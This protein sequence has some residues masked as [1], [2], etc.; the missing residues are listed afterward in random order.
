MITKIGVAVIAA[1][2]ASPALA[3][4]ECKL[5]TVKGDR[6]SYAFEGIGGDYVEVSYP[7][8]RPKWQRISKD[9]LVPSEMPD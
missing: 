3:S 7:D 1:L 2:I 6:I 5:T 8:R 9:T 4:F